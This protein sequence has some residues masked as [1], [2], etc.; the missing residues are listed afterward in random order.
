MIAAYEERRSELD[1]DAASWPVVC[2]GVG[3]VFGLVGGTWYG[4]REGRREQERWEHERDRVLERHD[5]ALERHD[6]ACERF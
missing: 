4:V 5:R 2:A 1:E 3:A 6:R